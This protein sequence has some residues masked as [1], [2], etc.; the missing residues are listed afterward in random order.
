[1]SEHTSS[2]FNM[3]F[4]P[5]SDPTMSE[6]GK[7]RMAAMEAGSDEAPAPAFAEIEVGGETVIRQPEVT[8]EPEAEPDID[9]AALAERVNKNA[10]LDQAD[11]D[12]LVA[13]ID[14]R[15]HVMADGRTLQASRW[16]KYGK[17]RIYVNVDRNAYLIIDLQTGER[18]WRITKL[19]RGVDVAE[20]LRLIWGL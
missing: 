13:H 18:E 1:M 14:T 12:W 3:F 6:E 19:T 4:A 17:E 2:S 10:A 15:E 11:R 9:R 7:G 8:A 5:S 16:A 20:A